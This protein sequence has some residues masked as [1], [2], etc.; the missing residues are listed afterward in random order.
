MLL[1]FRNFK[2]NKFYMKTEIKFQYTKTKQKSNTYK[3]D[4]LN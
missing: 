2:D 4:I 3:T 1:N